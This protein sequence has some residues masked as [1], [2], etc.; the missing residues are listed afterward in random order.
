MATLVSLGTITTVE[1]ACSFGVLCRL[2]R[3]WTTAWRACG[4]ACLGVEGGS[5]F[6]I[7]ENI[8]GGERLHTLYKSNM[9]ATFGM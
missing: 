8:T 3:C 7:T 4:L 1:G 9:S 5:H 2:S 6:L